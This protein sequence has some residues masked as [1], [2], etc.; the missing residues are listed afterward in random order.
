MLDSQLVRKDFLLSDEI[1]Y[2]NHGSFGAVPKV[3]L[4]EQ[5]KYQLL[6]ES[7][8]MHFFMDEAPKILPSVI[9]KIA[10]F[11]NCNPHSLSF[12][13]NATSGVNTVIRSLLPQMDSN[14]SIGFI[15]HVYPA[16]RQ[17]LN[18]AKD[19]S[20]CKLIEKKLAAIPCYDEIISAYKELIESGI[21]LLLIDAISSQTAIVFPL[22]EISE[23]AKKKNIDVLVDAAHS[24]GQIDL[25]PEEINCDWFTT[26]CHK[27]LFSP[28]GSAILWTS[29]EKKS[30]THPLTISMDYKKGYNYEFAWTGTK[31]ISSWM[32]IDKAIDYYNSFGKE[33]IMTYLKDL[34]LNVSELIKSEFN[35]EC[36]DANLNAA[37][38]TFIYP[39]KSDNP[40]RAAE[41]RY[42]F[43]KEFGIEMFFTWFE[44]DL[45]FRISSQI[46]L[47]KEDFLYFIDKMKFLLKK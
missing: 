26:N 1:Y 37:M 19:V 44:G 43:Y 12:V 46:Y 40:M 14:Y 29:E 39:E 9:N 3:V 30:Q 21:N 27:W 34:R 4:E 23:L 2:L 28:K 33:N 15:N 35:L 45:L 22:K 11:I 24:I 41:L 36:V 18:Y 42:Q 47:K 20:G 25:N 31:D 38:T 6:M 13:D 10:A 16:V 7:D 8:P 17:T 32:A 5:Q